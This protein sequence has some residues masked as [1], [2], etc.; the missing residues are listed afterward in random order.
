MLTF[1]ILT[2][3]LHQK[4]SHKITA[5]RNK[6]QRK[7]EQLGVKENTEF[8]LY[9]NVSEPVT[10][11]YVIVWSVIGLYENVLY[12]DELNPKLAPSDNY[13]YSDR[14]YFMIT[15]SIFELN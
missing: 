3:I 13:S 1:T 2:R 11:I 5:H 9:S 8:L 7:N 15:K 4:F 6:P 10:K 14:L 12:P